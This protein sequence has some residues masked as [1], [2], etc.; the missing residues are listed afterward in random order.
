MYNN[1]RKIIIMKNKIYINPENEEFGDFFELESGL[2]SWTNDKICQD[3][4][5]FISVDFILA[6]IK[7]L[8]SR[9][10]N[11]TDKTGIDLFNINSSVINELKNLLK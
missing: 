3:D 4:L 5:E 6:R 1:K 11:T 10:F 8:E 9:K 7:E 2:V